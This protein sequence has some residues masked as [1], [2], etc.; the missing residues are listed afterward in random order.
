MRYAD[1]TG[2]ALLLFP[3]VFDMAQGYHILDTECC[4]TYVS[5]DSC[6]S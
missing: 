5:T 6:G 4:L 1:E 3:A 2:L